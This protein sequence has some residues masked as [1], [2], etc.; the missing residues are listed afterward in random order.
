MRI[1]FVDH[2]FHQKTCSNAFFLALLRTLGEVRTYY[3]DT[4]REGRSPDVREIAGQGYDITVV[5]QMEKVLLRLL[6]AGCPNLVFVPMWDSCCYLNEDYWHRIAP[7]RIVS[8]SRHLHEKLLRL[9]NRSAHFQY[10]P[11]PE[12]FATVRDFTSRRGFFWQRRHDLNWRHIR[13]LLGDAHFARFHLHCAMDPGCGEAWQPPPRDVLRFNI[14]ATDWFEDRRDFEDQLQLSNIGFAPRLREGIGLTLLEMMTMGMCVAAPNQPVA[15]EYVRHGVNGLLFS[16]EDPRP[17]DFSNAERLGARA[18]ETVRLGHERWRRDAGDRLPAFLLGEGT[19]PIASL[20]DFGAFDRARHTGAAVPGLRARRRQTTASAPLLT[21]AVCIKNAGDALE[22]TLRSIVSQDFTDFE[23][24]VVDALSGDVTPDILARHRAAIDVLLREA[25]DGPYF[26]MNKAAAIARGRWICFMNAGDTFYA[27]DTLSR[28]LS[29]APASARLM[30]GHHV[31]RRASGEEIF[32]AAADFDLSWRRLKHGKLKRSWLRGLPCHQ[33]TFTETELLRA[34]AY[35]TRFAYA[36]DQ[37]FLFRMRQL[38]VKPYHLDDIIAVYADGG[39]SARHEADCFEEWRLIALQHGPAGPV[40][41]L[42]DR[43]QRRHKARPAPSPAQPRMV[44]QPRTL[45][46]R[47]L[48]WR[49]MRRNLKL[50]ERS[51]LFFERWYLNTYPDVCTDG[52]DPKLHYLLHGADEGRDPSPFFD[53]RYYLAANPDVREAGINPLV[54]YIIRGHREN[55]APNPWFD[56]E[57]DVPEAR[58]AP[59]IPPLTLYVAKLAR[60]PARS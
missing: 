11:D 41:A 43:L 60:T 30:F 58:S 2:S 23:L 42:Y 56:P 6:Q 35:D 5:F 27:S 24:V 47:L 3:D 54:H 25:D 39:L 10:F 44:P 53:T 22:P 15:N 7:V 8:F 14:T 29:V 12:G 48:S 59:G 46:G 19:A 26:A 21:V 38:G 51:S 37:D 36:A 52:M 32:V 49:E 9:G 40:N 50:I 31:F 55:R 18:R 1:A 17:L 28:A 20:H 57:R 45:I 33:A 13:A 34:N 4:W 16:A